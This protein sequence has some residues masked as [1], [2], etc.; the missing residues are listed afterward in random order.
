MPDVLSSSEPLRLFFPDR[1]LSWGEGISRMRYETQYAIDL[2]QGLE[3]L[4]AILEIVHPT[5][6]SPKHLIL[7]IGSSCVK[8]GMMERLQHLAGSHWRR[9]DQLQGLFVT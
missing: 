6:Q 3:Y 9:E 7:D 2:G 1:T 4:L 5:F 8:I